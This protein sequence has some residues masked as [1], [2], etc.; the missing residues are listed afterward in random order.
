MLSRKMN[1]F[2]R[3]HWIKLI[4]A[5]V[6]AV[7]VITLVLF[8]MT[9]LREWS[10]VDAVT[11]QHTVASMPFQLYIAMVTG[12]MSAVIFGVMWIFVING[13]MLNS[14]TKSTR[15]A[16]KGK[17][18]G[19]HW[20]DVIGMDE[21]K[22]E[23]NEVVGLIRDSMRPRLP[24]QPQVKILR[25]VLLLGPPG[26]GKTYL[27]KAIATEVDLPFLSLSG[28]EFVEIFVGVGAGRVRRLFKQARE[29]A[30]MEGGC[31]IFI[32]EVDAM[33]MSRRTDMGF[34]AQSERNTTL[35]QLLVEM[36]GLRSKSDNVVVFAA[37]NMP[38]GSMDEALLR[39]GRFDRKIAVDLPDMEDRRKLFE[40]YLSKVAY[41]KETVNIEQLAQS[42]V[43]SSP[44]Q[45]ANIV[46][47]A[48]IIAD[49]NRKPQITVAEISEARERIALGIKRLFK[50]TPDEKGRLAFYEAGHIL[51]TYL[52]VPTKDVFK[53]TILPRGKD[54]VSSLLTEKEEVLSRDKNLLLAE[55]R[56]ALAGFACEKIKFTVTSDIAEKDLAK[57][58]ELVHSMIWRWGMGKSGH[59]G[60]FDGRWVSQIIQMDLDK[61]A[62]ELL[63]L[64]IQEINTLL[65]DNWKI[66]ERLAQ[67]L[68][69]Q[70]ELDY[71]QIESIFNEY[72]KE[73][74]TKE[75]VRIQERKV[76]QTG[77]TW[78]DVIG[79]DETK[80]EAREVVELIKDRAQLQRVGGKIIKGLLLLGPPGCG[81]TY[82]ASAMATEFGLPFL[83][84]SGSE[85]V[86]M[87]V[88]VGAMR[89]RRMFQEAREL[90]QAQGGCVIFIDE[91]DALGAKRTSD[92]GTGGQSEYNQTL[93]Q[94]LVEMDGLK[95]QYAEY[96]IIVIGATNMP[97]DHF[98]AAL[99][100][101]GR[102]DRKLHIYLPNLEDREK[103]FRYYMSKVQYDPDS[104]RLDK[105]ARIT[106][107][108][109]PADIA[110]LVHEAAILA[111][112]NKKDAVTMVEIIEAMER[113]RLGLRL[114][115]QVKGIERVRTA[116]HEA[117]HAIITYLCE[118]KRDTFKVSI[119]QRE[120]TLGVSWSHEKDETREFNKNEAIAR[121]MAS[122]GGY[123]AELIKFGYHSSGVHGDFANIMKT[124]HQMVY[125]WGAGDSG[126]LGNFF[127]VY[128]E[129]RSGRPVL[130]DAMKARLDA[131]VQKIL[132]DC[133]EKTKEILTRERPL[134]DRFAS[135]LLAKEELD[136]DQMEAIFK[137]FGKPRPPEEV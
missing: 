8:I 10:S 17:D 30:S 135:E 5:A 74:P 25:G 117:G 70:N 31:I 103:L 1:V 90:A 21:A 22:K 120:R 107:D 19:V 115:F 62:Q 83:Y 101:P 44:A 29:L 65:R 55:V 97:E 14:F 35:N 76:I 4:V 69:D 71:H 95:Q 42:T 50:L 36:D 124:G 43:G 61:D 68:I 86:E 58:T 106:S 84:K 131:D 40:Y 23:A 126:L 32:D 128:G 119:V 113:I 20:A 132:K 57:A 121:I 46:H 7:V 123:V 52:L 28:S 79:M 38:E 122:L 104:V 37:T 80:Q 109:S 53:A 111:V 15:G 114:R 125:M 39:P 18:I 9:G 94:L 54:V 67:A 133:L 49:R 26:C 102:F 41:D 73:R 92:W 45:I 82:M 64:C 87:F 89:V 134:L 88:G 51:V 33:A 24:D 75:V 48:S 129:S 110:N 34:G 13:G 93:N 47:E 3:L 11:R 91:I 136:Y 81:K 78:A 108:Y 100:R 59:V 27:A 98:D 118:A 130:S 2:F 99:L 77:V 112:R 66:V 137:E 12:A 127:E 96:N 72:G 6:I 116:Y 105:M 16:V 85:F 60:N 63:E 56:I